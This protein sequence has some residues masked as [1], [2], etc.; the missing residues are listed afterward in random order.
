MALSARYKAAL[1][2]LFLAAPGLT[3]AD[4]VA[5]AVL[6]DDATK[7]SENRYRTNRSYEET[8]KFFRQVYGPAR[9]TRRQIVDRPGVKAVHIDNPDARPGQWE[10]LNVYELKGETRIFVLVKRR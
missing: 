6:P 1:V 3:F 7:V 9:Y 10:G 8:V 2:A 4:K 5:G